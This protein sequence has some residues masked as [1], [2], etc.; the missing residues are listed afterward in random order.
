[1]WCWTI[2]TLKSDT[3]YFSSSNMKCLL[4]DIKRFNKFNLDW[5]TLGMTLPFRI[6]WT[7]YYRN[8]RQTF[9][10]KNVSNFRYFSSQMQFMLNSIS[11]VQRRRENFQP[12]F[13]VLEEQIRKIFSRCI[14][15]FSNLRTVFDKNCNKIFRKSDYKKPQQ[16]NLFTIIYV[17]CK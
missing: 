2:R 1:M 6:L 4:H 3:A 8:K 17:I 12:L 9:L 14:Y 13:V 5:K 10:N 16:N 7:T 11:Y 15:I